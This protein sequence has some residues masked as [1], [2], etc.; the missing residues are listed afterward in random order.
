M[1]KEQVIETYRAQFD[2]F[3]HSL[4][5]DAAGAAQQR[6]RDAFSRFAEKGFPTMRDEDWRYTNLNPITGVLF[7]APARQEENGALRAEAETRALRIPGTITLLFVNGQYLPGLSDFASLPAGID[8]RDLPGVLAADD[9]PASGAAMDAS[10]LARNPFAELN[11]AFVQHGIVIT[12]RRNAVIEQ[13]LHLLFYS[14][15]SPQP[16]A[17]HPRVIVRVESGAQCSL[18]EQYAGAEGAVYFTNTLADVRV[19]DGGIL[20]HIKLQDESTSAFH[21]ASVY[22]DV[23]HAGVYE[24]HSIGFGA[25]LQRSNIHGVLAGEGA[26]CTMNGVFLPIGTQHMDHFT[27]IDHAVPNCTSHELYKGV[28]SDQT[29]GVFTGKI[30]VRQDAQKTDAKQANNNLLLSAQAQ[31]DT[32]PQLEIF[33]DDVKCTHGATVGRINDE[34]LFYLLSRG[35]DRRQAHNILTFA[36]ASDV[37]S[38]IPVAQLR[39]QLDGEIHRRLDASW[40]KK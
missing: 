12:V 15:A 16:F 32:R 7:E 37:V 17:A 33:A 3:E 18:I 39:D 22:A 10:V 35:I 6:R 31:I 14:S 19:E 26:H 25:A 13:P 20:R 24:H 23:A 34:Q 38:R 11:T 9:M 8:V 4:N 5:G 29:R 30:I 1:N 36:F 21:V 40:N 2:A 27:T 28:L